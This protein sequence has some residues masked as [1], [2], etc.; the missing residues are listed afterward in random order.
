MTSSIASLLMILV[1]WLSMIMFCCAGGASEKPLSVGERAE[2]L[3]KKKNRLQYDGEIEIR[4]CVH[5]G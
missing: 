4:W 5:Q 3:R 2:A 1:L